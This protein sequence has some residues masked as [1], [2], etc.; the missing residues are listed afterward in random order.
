[1]PLFA[2]LNRLTETKWPLFR[3]SRGLPIL[4]VSTLML[5][6]FTCQAIAL[7]LQDRRAVEGIP[8]AFGQLAIGHIGQTHRHR[9]GQ[10]FDPRTLPKNLF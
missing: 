4:S 10:E 8:V 7:L 9:F 1:M 2:I 6:L 5:P 3:G